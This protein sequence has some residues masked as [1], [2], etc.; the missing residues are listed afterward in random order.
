MMLGELPATGDDI[1]TLAELNEAYLESV[2][3]GDVDRFREILAD[4]FLCSAADGSVLDKTQF[5]ELTAG[6]RTL[7]HL[8]GSDVRIRLFGDV[9]IIHAATSY[10]TMAGS[11]RARAVHRR[12]GEA[13]RRLARGRG[14]RD[15][16]VK[17]RLAWAIVAA[18]SLAGLPFRAA[19][20]HAQPAAAD[21]E[22]PMNGGVDN[23][24]YSPLDADQPRQRRRAAGRVDLRLAR[25]LQGLRDAE[26]SRRRRRRALCDDADAEGRRGRCGDR[27][28]RSGSSIRAAARPTARGSGTAASPCTRIASS[29]RYRNFLWA[30]DRKTGAADR[31]VRHRR[32]HR[33]ARRARSAGRAAERQR[34]HAGRRS[35]R[36]C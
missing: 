10:T 23:I 33:S 1:A 15:A 22:W 16:A 13:R 9:A 36:T 5:L 17:R 35:S 26:Q 4:D 34:Q 7:R 18:I 12:L 20:V 24:R 2:K 14:A 29:S 25:R 11:R 21:A 8:S 28:A 31:V 6:P 27:A 32:P 30:L 3:M 19:D